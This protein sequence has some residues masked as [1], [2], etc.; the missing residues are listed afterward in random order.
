MNTNRRYLFIAETLLTHA[1]YASQ[2]ERL[3]DVVYKLRAIRREPYANIKITNAEG[4]ERIVLDNEYIESLKSQLCSWA[5]MQY[6]LYGQPVYLVG[7][8]LY[9]DSR[10]ID[11]RIILPNTEYVARFGKWGAKWAVCHE[12][13]EGSRRWSRT[14][15]KYNRYLAREFG[16]FG[17]VQVQSE[18]ELEYANA[19]EGP[20]VR[21]D[22]AEEEK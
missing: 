1:L 8:A 14:M 22:N 7:G 10:D 5:N 9:G 17:D 2:D 6:A 18:D 11:V 13:C 15:A 12:G 21:L 19:T 3:R 4:G 16:L 20:R